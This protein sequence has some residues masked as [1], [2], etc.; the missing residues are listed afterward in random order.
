MKWLVQTLDYL[1]SH[2]SETQALTEQNKLEKLI[3]RYKTLLPNLEVSMVK[4]ETLSKCYTYRREVREVCTLLT[5]VKDQ[6]KKEHIPENLEIIQQ[7]IKKQEG[8]V[9]HLEQQRS[10]IMSMLQKGKDLVK[11]EYSPRFVEDEIKVLELEWNDTYE[12][13]VDQLRKLKHTQNLWSNYNEQKQ[14]IV[15][16]LAQAE[17]E[18][19]KISSKHYYYGNLPAE[20]QAKQDMSIQL[21]EA[22]EE[23][24]RRLRDLCSNLL[25]LA[26]PEKKP[27][28]EKEVEDIEHRLHETLVNVDEHVLHLESVST[29][30]STFQNKIFDL[31]NWTVQNAPKLLSVTQEND[32]PPEERVLKTTLLQSQLAE[33]VNLLKFLENEAQ[34][35]IPEETDSAETQKIKSE[36]SA[37][38]SN[39]MALNTSI[40]NQYL[41]VNRDL[42]NWKRCQS[43]LQEIVPWVEEAEVK[44]SVGTSKPAT[45]EEAV[46]LQQQLQ[47]FG[48]E[49]NDQVERLRGV[50]EISQKIESKTSTPEEI[51]AIRSRLTIVENA[52]TQNAKKLDKLVANWKEFNVNVGT[53]QNWIIEKEKLVAENKTNLAAPSTDK[54]EKEL[55]KLKMLNNEMSE[56]HAKLI[57]LT[58]SSDTISHS[59]APEGASDVKISVQ[60]LKDKILRLA[61]NIRQRMNDVSDAILAKQEFQAKMTDFT[62]W[63]NKMNH[64]ISQTDEVRSDRV[65]QVLRTLHDITQEYSEKQPLFTSIYEE[66]KRIALMNSPAEVEPLNLDYSMMVE[67]YQTMESRLTRKRPVLE[68]WLDLLNWH[69]ESDQH[70]SYIKYQLDNQ[71]AKPDAL[72]QY[73]MEIDTIIE[74]IITWNETVVALDKFTEVTILDKNTEKPIAANQLLRDIEINSINLKGRIKTKLDEL[75]KLDAHWNQ[76]KQ[77]QNRIYEDLK[78]VQCKLDRLYDD[79]SK[80]E[81][82]EKVIVK[83]D[84]MLEE[85][86][87]KGQIREDLVR[88]GH[89]LIKDDAKNISVI[90]NILSDMDNN[91]DKIQDTIRQEKV[92]CGDIISDWNNFQESKLKI[93][94]DVVSITHSCDALEAPNDLI[95]ANINNDKA[96]KALESVKKLK[97]VLD[98]IDAKGETLIKKGDFVGGTETI[99]RENLKELHRQWSDAYE[100]ILKHVQV[101]DSQTVIWKNLDETKTK[102]L[103]WI[104]K[105]NADIIAALEKPNEVENAHIIL[106]KYKEE[107]PAHVS[108]KQSIPNKCKQLMKLNDSG[109]IPTLTTLMK[110]MDDQFE[111][112]KKN[113][114]KL[115]TAITVFEIKEKALKDDIKNVGNKIT[116][117]R[118]NVI[119]CEDLTGDN[120]RILERLKNCQQ[121]KQKLSDCEP[122]IRNIEK[123]IL[124]LKST[125]QSFSVSSLPKEHQNLM[126]RYESVVAHANKTEHSLLNFLKKFHNERY[127]ALQRIVQAQ[128]D[129]VQW[130]LPEPSS[131]KYNLE[132]KLNAL[133]P[134]QSAIDDCDNRK[135]ELEDSLSVLEEIESTEAVKLLKAE[136]DHLFLDLEDLKG[137]YN[138]IKKLLEENIILYQKYEALSEDTSGWLKDTENRVRVENT[139]QLNLDKLDEK[140]KEIKT[141]QLEVKGHQEQVTELSKLGQEIAKNMPESRITQFVQ[142]LNTRYQAIVKFLSSYLDKLDEL[143]N[144]KTLYKNSVQ[145]VEDWLIQAQNKV[146]SFKEYTSK[147]S[148]PNQATLTELKNFAVER[149]KGQQ[150]LN[151]AVENGE[152]LFSGIT[153]ENRD[154]IRSELRTLRDR[155]ETLIDEVNSIYKLV[156]NILMKRHSFDDSLAQV[157]TWIAD[158]ENKVGEMKLDENLT[159][160]KHTL[161]EYSVLAQDVNLHKNILEHLKLKTEQL[162]DTDADA[163]L[164]EIYD[165]YNALSKKLN[166][167]VSLAEEYVSNHEVY[168]QVLDKC[169]DW[170]TAL[171]GEAS[172]LVD[173]ISLQTSDT[174]ITVVD[175]LLAQKEEGDRII[176]SC[177]RQL[178]AVLEQTAEVGHPPLIQ[179]YEDQLQAWNKFLSTC[180]EAQVKLNDLFGQY[181]KFKVTIDDLENWLKQREAQV[182][183]QSLKSTLKAKE[184]HLDKLIALESEITDKA[185]NFKNVS[186]VVSTVSNDVDLTDKVSNLLIR[187]QSLRNF[188]KEGIGRY[189]NFV[190]EHRNFNDDYSEFIQWLNN[191][192]DDLQI[193]SHIVGDV[194]ILQ[195]RQQKVNDL[196]DIKNEKLDSFEGLIEHGEKLYSHTS[197]DGREIIRQQLRN[198]R[199]IW[200]GFVEDLQSTRTKLEMCLAQFSDFTCTQ[201]ELTQWLRDVERAMQ[202]H[203]K[204]NNT[205]QE[206]RAQLQNHKIMN[207]DITSHQQ[208]VE[209]LCNKA[210]HLVDQTQDK[211]L[212]VCIQ[213]IKQLFQS[214]VEKSQ[215]LFKNLTDS[216]EKHNEFNNKISAFKNW[217]TGESEKL[218]D[219][220]DVSGE[221]GDVNKRI[222]VLKALKDNEEE[223]N[224]LLE[225]LKEQFLLVS[226]KTAPK[227]IEQLT[228]ELEDVNLGMKGHFTEIGKHCNVTLNF[229]KTSFFQTKPLKNKTTYFVNGGISKT[230]IQ[231]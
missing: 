173:E 69:T 140:I 191:K 33:K 66:V 211:S 171:S 107:L 118:E 88:Q 95:Q 217:L 104:T 67:N 54:L 112:V 25:K 103:L 50:L 124:Q 128:K 157:R 6:V 129:K 84:E 188:I 152:A 229:F 16:L 231:P 65:E 220:D 98:K 208:L 148:K 165:R 86:V 182:K 7:L 193:M 115:E 163:K 45:L 160:K 228:A 151:K 23:M 42:D 185:D 26:P 93:Q 161:H 201:Q 78:A 181:S 87:E 100:K 62:S 177:K 146:A 15:H 24:L 198:I 91:W 20:L 60:E 27:T 178:D 39:V 119:K 189:E 44:I 131:D 14:E 215:D 134:I 130:C 58:Q 51:N 164:D 138:K 136:R 117:I 143:N 225:E 92:K 22:T 113:V 135:N 96:K 212:N 205:L 170:L 210:Q 166:E 12:D 36:I 74:K 147:S 142:H 68:K 19:K 133:T 48:Q 83:L 114:D 72:Q 206:K 168:V 17:G 35:L 122:D 227:G 4:T 197:P 172:I 190:K 209:T 221:K 70:L 55:A 121:L 13:S 31:Q 79:V 187:Y 90:Q 49:Y 3:L 174:K 97:I 5:K 196:I 156:E 10:N 120:A 99:V 108:L 125:Y 76:F 158:A 186:D 34:E 80:P 155:S 109:E 28:L 176:A 226:K 219:Q 53:M 204:L 2:C 101:T 216:V 154:V 63:M 167:R 169:R 213:S 64:N 127:G 82:L 89:Q 73:I 32:V 71:A 75:Q 94:K 40:E 153:S 85:R 116:D 141:L 224:K 183:D 149:E 214:I 175:N 159:K 132:V 102:I 218:R 207:Q 162:S 59:L 46:M 1:T 150:L 29:K 30:W 11:E 184:A 81:D 41:I 195:E 199:T 38:Q 145:D 200:D 8:T 223:G 52:R 47:Q 106:S 144:F 192:K 203:N 37:L 180:S 222:A 230:S 77:L 111:D 110:L 202:Q 123:E 18:L 126:K 61:E 194:N 179:A 43:T 57:N 137:N 105:Q 21:R 9:S 56:Q 139:S